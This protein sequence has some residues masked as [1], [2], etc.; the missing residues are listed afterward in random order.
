LLIVKTLGIG[1]SLHYR[2]TK[3]D[4]HV[5]NI[6]TELGKLT[7]KERIE[8]LFCCCYDSE[9]DYI[10]KY[11]ADYIRWERSNPHKAARRQ[12]VID[13]ILAAATNP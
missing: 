11:L 6:G 12:H 5:H 2:P 4:K 7:V 8:A 10:S 13:A 3:Q 9:L 1:M